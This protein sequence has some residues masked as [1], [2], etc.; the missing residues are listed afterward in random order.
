MSSLLAKLRE[1]KQNR[2]KNGIY[3][4]TQVKLCYNSNRI[5]GSKLTEEQTR[6]I[7]ETNSFIAD[8]ETVW[9]DDIIEAKNHFAAF[10]YILDHAKDTLSED[11]IKTIHK[12]IVNGTSNAQKDWFKVGDYKML[13]NTVSDIETTPPKMVKRA[14]QNLLTEYNQKD[15]A[16]FNDV[17]KFHF[18]FEKIHPFQDGNGRVGRLLMF[19]EC[20]KNNI[21]PF[22]IDNEHKLFYYRGLKE[23][24]NT[25]GYLTDTCLSA[26]DTYKGYL[27]Y[28]NIETKPAQ[29]APQKKKPSRDDGYGR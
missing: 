18:H 27:K 23:F 16:S 9:V 3:H 12:T 17:V 26:Q 15:T 24:E 20:L 14:V 19:K 5:E 7:F 28:F 11:I 22:I 29:N 8:K 6:F 4:L 10:N 1:E 2:F 13:A 21:T 25:P